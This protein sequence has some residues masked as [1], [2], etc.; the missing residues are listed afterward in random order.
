MNDA[1]WDRLLVEIRDLDDID[2]GVRAIET[3]D[4]LASGSDV[5]RL[6]DLL[7]DPEF[8]VREA[9]AAPL[10]RLEGPR[11]LPALFRALTRGEQDGHDNDGLTATVCDLLEVHAAAT[12][13]VVVPMLASTDPVD[14]AR[15]AWALGFVASEASAEPL[16][17]T[18]LHDPDP[19]ARASAAGSLSSFPANADVYPALV[20][21]LD[22]AD[23][24]VRVAAV[25]S[26]GYLGD[27]RAIDVLRSRSGRSN[28][29]ERGMIDHA[30]KTLS[31]R[32]A[33]DDDGQRAR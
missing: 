4:R 29:A 14:R 31:A 16:L 33:R 2:R 9:A 27:L 7:D 24:P 20:S 25:S 23:E 5:P 17:R 28:P 30:I 26:L 1:E 11:A 32:S 13:A 8:F 22:D 12:S 3:L 15:A 21:A 6:Y 10:A 19:T 18:L